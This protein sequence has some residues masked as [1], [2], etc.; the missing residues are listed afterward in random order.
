[1]TTPEHPSLRTPLHTHAVLTFPSGGFFLFTVKH[2]PR[3]PTAL[4]DVR[5]ASWGNMTDCVC[6]RQPE[7]QEGSPE[8]GEVR[9]FLLFH[10][11]GSGESS[12][13]ARTWLKDR[14]Q[15]SVMG[16]VVLYS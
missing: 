7:Q 16:C 10:V 15:R 12:G 9:G 4:F 11:R 2:T 14:P 8:Q 13:K 3:W 1:M 5:G 6:H